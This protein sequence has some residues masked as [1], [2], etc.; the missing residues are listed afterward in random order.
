MMVQ[1]VFAQKE[2]IYAILLILAIVAIFFQIRISM[3]IISTQKR[4]F[5]PQESLKNDSKGKPSRYK[6]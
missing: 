3:K 5:P 4:N 2:K 6:Y 1:V